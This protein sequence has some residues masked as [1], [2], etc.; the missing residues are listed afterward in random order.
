MPHRQSPAQWLL[1]GALV[2][3]AAPC[4]ADARWAHGTSTEAGTGEKAEMVRAGI[5]RPI[6]RTW[7]RSPARHL[8]AYW[9]LTLA[10]WRGDAYR[11]VD[12]ARQYFWDLGLTPVFRY[13]RNDGLGWYAEAGVGIHYLSDL[14]DN[15]G[16]QLS[17]RFQFGDHLGVG[18]VLANGWELGLKFQH[19]SNGS[20]KAPNAGVNF[21]VLK[22]AYR[23]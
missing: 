14:Y 20:I 8:G 12:G 21:I 16:S 6:G 15:N 9:D 10:R 3:A 11:N 2:A 4:A 17:T 7:L 13:Q 5:Q 22:A 1:A 23:F 19:F 18:Y